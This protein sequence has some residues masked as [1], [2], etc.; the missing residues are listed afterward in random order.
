MRV[1][2]QVNDVQ[3]YGKSRREVVSF[4]KEVPPPFTLVCCRHPT[5]DLE[6]ELESESEPEPE[7]ALRPGSVRQSQPSVEEVRASRNTHSCHSINDVMFLP[8]DPLC[9]VCSDRAEA[10]VDVLQ[11]DRTEREQR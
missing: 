4:L 2:A 5:S 6:P 10:V 9:R 3:L 7:P 8:A 1:C 11:S